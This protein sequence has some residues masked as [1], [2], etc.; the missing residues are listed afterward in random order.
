M[1]VIS[2]VGTSGSGSFSFLPA[3]T[4]VST[5]NLNATYSNGTAGVGATL[6]NAGSQAAI[7]ID[8]V[9]L[10]TAGIVLVSGQT[11]TYQNGIYGVT[12]VGDGSHN[13]VLTRVTYF[14]TV[15]Q[16]VL[17][18]GTTI[19]S[20][21]TNNINTFWYLTSV[22][23]SIGSSAITF[24]QLNLAPPNTYLQATNNL[25]D[26]MSGSAALSNLGGQPVSTILTKVA[27]LTSVAGLLAIDTSGNAYVDSIT[28]TSNQITVSN[29]TGGASNPTIAIATGYA[30]QTSITTLG[31]VATGTWHGSVIGS[32]YGGTGVNNGSSTLTLGGNLTTS[33]AY[34]STFTMTGATSVTFPT[35]GTLLSTTSISGYLTSAN[36]LSDVN[37]ASTSLS[38]LGGQPTNAFLTSLSNLS[39]GTA[40][41]LSFSSG[42]TAY[43]NTITGTSNQIT[44][45]N[46]AGG[47]SNPTIS[48]ATGYVG[49][50]S[51][52]TL[53]TIGTGTWAGTLVGS[54][55]GGTGV[56][57]GSSTIT[58]GGNLTT[59][60]ANTLTLT[61]SGN[62]NVTLPT[63]GTLATVAGSLQV[64]N[65]LSDVSSA[66]TSATNLGLGTGNTPEF[67]GVKLLNAASETVTLTLA[68]SGVTTSSYNLP[69]A[70]P[71][72]GGTAL[73]STTGGTMSWSTNPPIS[74]IVVQTFTS[75]NTYT[76]TVGM[77]YCIVE[78]VGTGGGGAG[79][80]AVV[81][82][83]NV[84]GGGGGSGYTRKVITAS[85][86]GASQTVTIGA[87]GAGGVG[88][89]A[90]GTGGTCSFGAIL[91]VT[92]GG[93]G[94]T[95]TTN[96]NSYL[97]IQSANGADGVGSGGDL[98]L[99]GFGIETYGY[100]FGTGSNASYSVSCSGGGSFWANGATGVTPSGNG[101]GGYLG[102]GGSGA[103]T[104][105]NTAYNGGAGGTGSCVITEYCAI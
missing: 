17:G 24:T 79:V 21:S 62:T 52:T 55:Y 105:T 3:S 86:V 85:A 28:G 64:A 101:N 7:V 25:D 102:G 88:N 56:N 37:S 15:G 20:G 80:P 54:T 66:T 19:T 87:A 61:T 12:T 83:V 6:T 95:G 16:M 99:Y 53:G 22:V 8:G 72:T 11:T 26:V 31:T 59:S 13:W 2:L 78:L 1:A 14:D 33:G 75:T 43:Q 44:I 70:H 35:S 40:G 32:T 46:G 94:S 92:G 100:N 4:V 103:C 97:V 69:V 30:G 34:N 84:G 36:N 104:S 65:N 90:G 9:S 81:S 45:A 41:L 39:T 27:G 49:Q 10:T 67:A 68:A 89:N 29:G 50:T 23:S 98:N 42:G 47:A 5:G 71:V 77:Q 73:L 74:K 18:A 82:G 63:S 60:G 93:G 48:I 38:N 57:N 76:P 96:T 58:L 51:I 91:S